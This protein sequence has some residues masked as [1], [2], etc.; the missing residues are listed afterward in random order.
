MQLPEWDSRIC[1]EALARLPGS[2]QV[3]VLWHLPGFH[4]AV[5]LRSPWVL[6][7][8]TLCCAEEPGWVTVHE[9]RK[10]WLQCRHGHVHTMR[11]WTIYE[12]HLS[13][14]VA[15]I[16]E[17]EIM[18]FRGGQKT[19]HR[20]KGIFKRHTLPMLALLVGNLCTYMCTSLFWIVKHRWI[21]FTPARKISVATSF[22]K[23]LYQVTGKRDHCMQLLG[24]EAKIQW[25]NA[26]H[27]L[28]YP[29]VW[30]HANSTCQFHWPFFSKTQR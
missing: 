2:M 7:T 26:C 6:T 12:C 11:T 23:A 15:Q 20:W 8:T 29:Y 28:I 21:P 1:W 22:V 30:V 13:M 19:T 16:C 5:T 3:N 27:H 25:V 9:E 14:L 18:A 4:T 17:T 24:C 10:S